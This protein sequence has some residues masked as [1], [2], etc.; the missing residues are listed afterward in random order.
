MNWRNFNNRLGLLAFSAA[1]IMMAGCS[2]DELATEGGGSVAPPS[3]Q[4][5][6]SGTVNFTNNTS[7]T[8]GNGLDGLTRAA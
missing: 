3:G 1:A 4:T 8:I 2:A 7:M 5:A 6:A